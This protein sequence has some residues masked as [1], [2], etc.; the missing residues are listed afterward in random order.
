MSFLKGHLPL[1]VPVLVIPSYIF[2]NAFKFY[3]LYR[4]VITEDL[5]EKRLGD[6]NTVIAKEIGFGY[7]INKKPLNQWLKGFGDTNSS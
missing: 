2:V 4:I 1:L 3:I 7:I 6:N 5:L